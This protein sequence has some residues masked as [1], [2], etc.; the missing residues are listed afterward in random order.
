MHVALSYD[1]FCLFFARAYPHSILK[2]LNLF[3]NQICAVLHIFGVLFNHLRLI[4]V[5]MDTGLIA[6]NWLFAVQVWGMKV[7]DV[8]TLHNFFI[9]SDSELELLTI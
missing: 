5:V 9:Y 3:R 1:L 2:I 4:D 7:L 8:I 6:Q